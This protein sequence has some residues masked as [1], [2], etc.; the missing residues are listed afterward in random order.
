MKIA[1]YIN[2]LANGGAER[3]IANLAN[4]FSQ[5]NE[6]LVI[7]SFACSNEYALNKNVMHI[8]YWRINE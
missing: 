5:S 1:F 2:I 8:H 6:V 3:V 4:A 7:T